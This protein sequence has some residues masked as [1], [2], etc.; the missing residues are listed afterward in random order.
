MPVHAHT[1]VLFSEQGGLPVGRAER[2][3]RVS[4]G[5]VA[6]WWREEWTANTGYNLL[7]FTITKQVTYICDVCWIRIVL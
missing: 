5:L 7:L 1:Q 2:V 3:L 6:V 4:E